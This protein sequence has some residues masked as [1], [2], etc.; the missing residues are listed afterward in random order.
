M[1]GVYV[2]RDA[3]DGAALDDWLLTRLCENMNRMA[4]DRQA[5]PTFVPAPNLRRNI[6]DGLL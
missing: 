4:R 3:R 5:N 2:L 1:S 6:A